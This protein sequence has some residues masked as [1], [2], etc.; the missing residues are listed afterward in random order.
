MVAITG[1]SWDLT[2]VTNE[3]LSNWAGLAL[4]TLSLSQLDLASL[5]TVLGRSSALTILSDTTVSGELSKWAVDA[6]VGGLVVLLVALTG[7]SW[8]LA[9]VTNEILSNWACLALIALSLAQLNL[10]SLI[11]VLRGSSALTVL[12]IS[13]VT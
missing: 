11:T 1:W 5:I 13:T 8:D 10:T 3:I 7:W 12:G 2:G 4:E 9:V 6:L